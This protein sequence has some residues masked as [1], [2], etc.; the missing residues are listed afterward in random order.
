MDPL[1]PDVPE[2][3]VARI[4]SPLLVE[5]PDPVVKLIDPPVALVDKPL[6]M[7]MLPPALDTPEPT[8]T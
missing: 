1:M 2:S 4:I 6:V 8:L 7:K 3:A 5:L